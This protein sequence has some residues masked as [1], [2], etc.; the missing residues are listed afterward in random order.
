MAEKKEKGKKKKDG[1]LPDVIKQAKLGPKKPPTT[2]Y[3]H[4]MREREREG[5]KK[6]KNHHHH[7]PQQRAKKQKAQ[8]PKKPTD[9]WPQKRLQILKAKSDRRRATATATPHAVVAV[10]FPQSNHLFHF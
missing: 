5:R 9:E 1:P 4:P 3:I 2:T 8:I 6:E 10:A 7:H